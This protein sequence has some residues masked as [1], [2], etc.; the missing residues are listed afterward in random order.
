MARVGG[1]E[2]AC[3]TGDRAP[4]PGIAREIERNRPGS[5]GKGGDRAGAGWRG[6]GISISYGGEGIGCGI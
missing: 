6:K 3:G 1:K 4:S 5:C 2:M